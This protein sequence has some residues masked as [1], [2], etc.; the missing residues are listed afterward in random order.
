MK[1][2]ELNKEKKSF[3][4]HYRGEIYDSEWNDNDNFEEVKVHSVAGFL[5]DEKGR[6]CL[7]RVNKSRGWTL[8]G[9]RIEEYDKTP[10]DALKR[11]AEEEADIELKN[12]KRLG[13]W[14]T[15]P[16]KNPK[17][18]N[19]TGRFVAEI[20][21]IKPQ[22]IDPA[23]NIICERIFISPKDFDKYTRWG[24]NGIFQIKKALKMMGR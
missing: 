4:I 1:E 18:I 17:E 2:K 3:E 9:G 16:R 5:F 14:K 12:I 10:E 8:V 7:V 22:T 24:D 23:E 6:I 21:K 20:K 13:Y 15:S 11:E 19:Y